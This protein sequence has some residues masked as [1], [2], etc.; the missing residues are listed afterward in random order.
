MRQ[1]KTLGV[2]GLLAGAVVLNGLV[3][4][5]TGSWAMY[6]HHEGEGHKHYSLNYEKM[7]E[8]YN[9]S[10]QQTAE[11]KAFHEKSQ[12]EMKPL[13][14]ELKAKKK[15]LN[16]Y[17]ERDDATEAEALAMQNDISQHMEEIGQLRIKRWFELKAIAPESFMDDMYEQHI[18]MK[19]KWKKH[20]GYHG[21]H[22]GEG[23]HHHDKST[24][25]TGL[26]PASDNAALL[27][28]GG[29]GKTDPPTN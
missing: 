19:S 17:L 18:K 13:Y 16:E 11:L 28:C 15:A 23:H 8:K 5:F 25:E 22:H 10:E 9:L 1:L 21:K 3:G 24:K 27:A 6:G 29:K 20:H 7:A 2:A 14:R 12:E 26:L 4:S